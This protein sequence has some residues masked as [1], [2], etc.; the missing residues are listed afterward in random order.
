MA[1]PAPGQQPQQPNEFDLARTR[2][3]QQ[4]NAAIQQQKEAIKRRAAAGGN[5]NSGAFIKQERQVEQQGQ[6]N[7]QQANEGIDTAQR[8]ENRRVAEVKEGRDFASN[9]AAMQRKFMA[10]ESALQRGM[11]ADQ[12]A[13]TFGLSKEQFEA[14]KAQWGTQNTAAQN[15]FEWMKGQATEE[16]TV[17]KNVNLVTTLLSGKNSGLTPDQIGALLE[18]LTTGV[19][20]TLPGLTTAAPAAAPVGL[21]P[22][23]QAPASAQPS[24]SYGSYYDDWLKKNKARG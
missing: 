20:P 16:A 6:Q 9:E 8:A 23:G 22:S 14:Q 4:N 10:A 24:S 2:A 17:A 7:L 12:F 3:S 11:Q 21:S 19:M 18:G 15:Q 5:L 1:A 13:K